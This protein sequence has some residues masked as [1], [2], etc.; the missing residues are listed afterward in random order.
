MSNHIGESMTKF[1]KIK[2]LK[3][4]VNDP[5]VDSIS[6]ERNGWSNDGI[7]IY[8]K[9]PYYNPVTETSSIHEWSVKECLD[10]LNNDIIVNEQYWQ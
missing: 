8:L 6:D 7:W 10:I 1:K 9:P 2:T 4:T 5:R 3:E